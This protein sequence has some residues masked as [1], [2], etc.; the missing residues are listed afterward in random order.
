[1]RHKLLEEQ[2][3]KEEL[4]HIHR[5][6]ELQLLQYKEALIEL[7][8][9]F[10]QNDDKAH[11]D[12]DS[13]LMIDNQA[14][15]SN[16]L[17]TTNDNEKNNNSRLSGKERQEYEAQIETL[18]QELEIAKKKSQTLDKE[19]RDSLNIMSKN[20]FAKQLQAARDTHS[21]EETMQLEINELKDQLYE[22]TKSK[23]KLLQS[24]HDTIETLRFVCFVFFFCVYSFIFFVCF[25]FLYL[26]VQLCTILSLRWIFGLNKTKLNKSK[27]TESILLSCRI[28]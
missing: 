6:S 23:I 4:K 2:F 19:R 9:K 22:L 24:T 14:R 3:E 15:N 18:K 26:F 13:A 8:N 7:R 10:N 21:L 20:F 12:P 28:D 11:L 16:D 25:L 17:S 5:K 1:M 27:K